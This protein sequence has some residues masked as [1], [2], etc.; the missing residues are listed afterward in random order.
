MS[1]KKKDKMVASTQEAAACSTDENQNVIPQCAICWQEDD[2]TDE[3]R[4]LVVLPCCGGGTAD[5]QD[6]DSPSKQPKELSFSTR[7]CAGCIKNLALKDAPNDRS[8]RDYYISTQEQ[9][10]FPQS[11]FYYPQASIMECIESQ[12][13]SGTFSKCIECP[14]C[15]GLLA[16]DCRGTNENVSY[17]L[18]ASEEAI[19]PQPLTR[20]QN[21]TSAKPSG[22]TNFAQ[23]LYRRHKLLL[24][25]C[26]SIVVR[27]PSFLARVMY[28]GQKRDHA[29]QLWKLAYVPLDS[30]LMREL[31][32]MKVESLNN[33]VRWGI[34]E[35][36][37]LDT[38]ES[39]SSFDYQLKKEDQNLLVKIF[40]S[41]N[42]NA[43]QKEKEHKMFVELLSPTLSS[44]ARGYAKKG[45]F[46]RSITTFQHLGNLHLHFNGLLPPLPLSQEQ[47]E[48][49]K[50]LHC[51][52]I[53]TIAF[54]VYAFWKINQRP[55]VFR[56][57]FS[58]KDV[59][60]FLFGAFIVL[61]KGELGPYPLF[62]S[63][64][65]SYWLMRLGE[66]V[67]SI[68]APEQIHIK[69]WILDCYLHHL[70][71]GI[72]GFIPVATTCI[73]HHLAEHQKTA[74]KYRRLQI[75]REQR[76]LIERL[77]VERQQLLLREQ[78]LHKVFSAR[79][80]Q[81]AFR[82]FSGNL[83]SYSS[84]QKQTASEE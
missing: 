49:L 78:M 68:L 17:S 31:V 33:L 41:S 20:Y 59:Q 11:K 62:G 23:R 2:L 65:I 25:V 8:S 58:F 9:K 24:N 34:L 80:I 38:N 73:N 81:K 1:R 71:T 60:L 6:Q 4:R 66:I 53:A 48:Q 27:K 40:E 22:E 82:S 29:N 42:K 79:K 7:F 32:E 5:V 45:Y 57:Q 83:K 51:F 69:F 77:L 28:A 56:A 39:T 3:W 70:V 63:F 64:F 54:L 52:C 12:R 21:M 50:W 46:I 16:V 14:R 18:T 47:E 43:E 44:M 37:A 19:F 84:T 61:S 35:K 36:V 76:I 67:L 15:K 13:S 30:C 10:E 72:L 55:R 74:E 75:Q 26:Q